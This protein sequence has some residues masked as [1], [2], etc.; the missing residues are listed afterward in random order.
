MMD[1]LKCPPRVE[2]DEEVAI[3]D[4]LGGRNVGDIA[5]VE[6]IMADWEPPRPGYALKWR[7][8][9]VV[10]FTRDFYMPPRRDIPCF[11]MGSWRFN[12][13][14]GMHQATTWET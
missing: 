14:N 2:G 4:S 6:G 13:D 8:L 7:C 5:A 12:G 9:D 10:A 11:S 1:G 3:L